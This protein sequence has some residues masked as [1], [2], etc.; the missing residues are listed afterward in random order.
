[1]LA[2]PLF[3]MAMWQHRRTLAEPVRVQSS[4]P[5]VRHEP[6]PHQTENDRMRF[7]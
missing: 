6:V 4:R 2:V 7:R 1:M 3:A 5:S